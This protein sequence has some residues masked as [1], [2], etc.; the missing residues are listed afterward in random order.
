LAQ[1]AQ[2]AAEPGSPPT[3]AGDPVDLLVEKADGVAVLTLHRPKA[4]NAL[5]SRLIL[6]L[7]AA[8]ADADADPDVGAVILTGADP[9]FCAGLDLGEIA[10]TGENLRLA[11]A[12]EGGPPAG[13]P[14]LPLST[15][16]I[17]AVNGPAVTG[18]LELALHCD[19]LIASERAVFVDT[20]ARVGVLPSWGMTVLLPRAVGAG[21]ARRMS[22]TGDVLD[23]PAALRAGLVTEVVAHNELMDAARRVARAVLGADPETRTA[24]L[25]SVHRLAGLDTAAAFAA[26]NGASARWLARGFDPA[27]VAGRRAGVVAGNR[28]RLAA[29]PDG[30]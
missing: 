12:V 4:R 3:A 27:G 1:P 17:G 11:Q 21:L 14:W 28:D 29:R 16:L 8:L 5:T 24:L 10:G 6:R 26:E 13:Y 18:G 15:P 22:L 2:P 23:A 30:R 19:I 7:R 9:A 20:H 25:D